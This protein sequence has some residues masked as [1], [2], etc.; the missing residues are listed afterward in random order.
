MPVR[1]SV[2]FLAPTIKFGNS[3]AVPIAILNPKGERFQALG[4]AAKLTP[5]GLRFLGGFDGLLEEEEGGQPDARFVF[6][7]RHSESLPNLKSR[8]EPPCHDV[9]AWDPM[10]EIVEELTHPIGNH[11]R[12]LQPDQAAMLTVE[13]YASSWQPMSDDGMGTSDRAHKAGVR[14]HRRFHFCKLK[15]PPDFEDAFQLAGNILFPTYADLATTKGGRCRGKVQSG[16][17]RGVELA[18]NL[19][20][21]G[22]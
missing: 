14:T 22:S 6:S 17:H 7:P 10:R 13:Y 11:P 20:V 8:F 1:I 18:D 21:E 16:L 3:E 4:G 19:G 15:A 2:A 12:V 5:E 9:I